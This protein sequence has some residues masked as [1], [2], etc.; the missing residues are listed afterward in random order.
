MIN[1][2]IK[3]TSLLWEARSWGQG[4]RWEERVVGLTC[5]RK[6]LCSLVIVAERGVRP[7]TYASDS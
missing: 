5:L 1:A 4:K 7:L 6:K 3:R 2:T